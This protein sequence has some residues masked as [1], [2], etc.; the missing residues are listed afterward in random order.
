MDHVTTQLP[1]AMMAAGGA[2]ALY[3]V[4]AAFIV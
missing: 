2:A 1:L 4:L 3:T